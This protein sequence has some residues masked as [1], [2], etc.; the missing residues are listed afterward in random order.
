[1]ALTGAMKECMLGPDS[2]NAKHTDRAKYKQLAVYKQRFM[3]SV[4]RQNIY[5]FLPG[6]KRLILANVGI[7]R[8]QRLDTHADLD[9]CSVTPSALYNTETSEIQRDSVACNLLN[10]NEL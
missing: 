2:G 6:R 7:S 9:R 4:K 8:F 1:M 5:S 3:T 10:S